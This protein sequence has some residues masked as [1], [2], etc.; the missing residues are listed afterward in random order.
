[1]GATPL[2]RTHAASVGRW[3][4]TAV[5][6]VLLAGVCLEWQQADTLA[7]AAAVA[8]NVVV[9][10]VA[11]VVAAEFRLTQTRAE[12]AGPESPIQGCL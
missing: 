8:A 6:H 3:G 1:V 12:S 4:S 5:G 9:A 7:V 10:G 2:R 11:G